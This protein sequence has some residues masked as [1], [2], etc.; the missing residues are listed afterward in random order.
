MFTIGNLA[1]LENKRALRHSLRA[2]YSAGHREHYDEATFTLQPIRS[3]GSFARWHIPRSLLR[4]F[5]FL[6]F[7]SE[8]LGTEDAAPVLPRPRR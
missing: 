1:S 2:N 7:G 6:G 4:S 5:A 3:F 8:E